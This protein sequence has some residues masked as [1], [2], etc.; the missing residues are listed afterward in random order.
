MSSNGNIETDYEGG[1][2]SDSSQDGEIIVVGDH[3][4]STSR[5][6]PGK[7]NIFK[8]TW[9]RIKHSKLATQPKSWFLE[10]HDHF[11]RAF[12]ITLLLATLVMLP[13]IIAFGG[14]SGLAN[15]AI[16][17][18]TAVAFVSASVA[19]ATYIAR[20]G[21]ERTSTSEK[22]F[23]VIFGL[24]GAATP[25][26]LAKY[27]MNVPFLGALKGFAYAIFGLRAINTVG[28]VGYRFG[29]FFNSSRPTG[30]R[31]SVAVSGVIWGTVGGIIATKATAIL[32]TS[33]ISAIVPGMGIAVALPVVPLAIITTVVFMS[34]GA[35]AMDYT[36]KGVNYL[37]YLY[38]TTSK[39]YTAENAP[40]AEQ[41]ALITRVGQRENEYKLA[42]IGVVAGAILGGVIVGLA[43]PYLALGFAGAAAVFATAAVV[44]L[45]VMTCVSVFGSI[46]ANLG[47]YL[48]RKLVAH[49]SSLTRPLVDPSQNHSQ[50]STVTHTPN[51]SPSASPKSGVSRNT[52]FDKGQPS[53]P[54]A[55]SIGGYQPLPDTD[56]AVKLTRAP[57][58]T[59]KAINEPIETP[60]TKKQKINLGSETTAP[61]TSTAK[62]TRVLGEKRKATDDLQELPGAKKQKLESSSISGQ[63]RKLEVPSDALQQSAKKLKPNPV[64]ETPKPSSA[65]ISIGT[66]GLTEVLYPTKVKPDDALSAA[67]LLRKLGKFKQPGTADRA[68]NKVPSKVAQIKPDITSIARQIPRLAAAAAA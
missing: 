63:K 15:A 47:R 61:I 51:S 11:Q 6:I 57:G 14:F 39:K 28:G 23:T 53:S 17:I 48:D 65:P 1:Y 58:I 43:L 50:V 33:T 52:S 59:Q 42:G 4:S 34:V 9:R 20:V 44:T 60:A 37:R 18:Y 66:S 64:E 35:S 31:I 27:A 24:L 10:D 67:M 68:A 56:S 8:R 49:H 41:R 5:V 3:D 29:G 62:L 7:G 2:E 46:A 16:E 25:I 55:P 22:I 38:Y 54:S 12:L 30:E 40:S 26:P 13:L 45:A 19:G 21:D 36:A 32:S